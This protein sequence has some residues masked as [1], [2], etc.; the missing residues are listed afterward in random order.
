MSSF[1]ISIA[2]PEIEADAIRNIYAD[3]IESEQDREGYPGQILFFMGEHPF[4]SNDS[5]ALELIQEGIAAEIICGPSDDGVIAP[6]HIFIRDSN[7]EL[8]A[9]CVYNTT[10]AQIEVLNEL[11]AQLDQITTPGQ[12][13]T[14]INHKISEYLSEHPV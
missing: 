1:D 5:I 3:L 12:V 10:I 13:Q 2:V 7:Q 8:K 14:W 4:G 6:H 11:K 9:F